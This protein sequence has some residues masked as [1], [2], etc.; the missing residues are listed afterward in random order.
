MANRKWLLII[1]HVI[2]VQNIK[3]KLMTK[4]NTERK[5]IDGQMNKLFQNSTNSSRR[6]ACVKLWENELLHNKWLFT[7]SLNVQQKYELIF[8][9]YKCTISIIKLWNKRVHRET[10]KCKWWTIKGTCLFG[11]STKDEETCDSLYGWTK[12]A[13][14]N[15][16]ISSSQE[17]LP[18][19]CRSY[20]PGT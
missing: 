19:R 12:T 14:S 2:P 6:W 17:H 11:T 10:L 7:I 3:I 13:Q 8:L 16:V 20:N 4:Y 15:L 18:I 5:V 1:S 9:N